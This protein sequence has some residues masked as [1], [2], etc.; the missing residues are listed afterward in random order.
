MN[1]LEMHDVHTHILGFH[2]LEGVSFKI[3]PAKVSVLLGRN[4]AGKSTTMKTIMGLTPPASGEIL[5]KGKPIQKMRDFEIPRLGISLVPEGRDVFSNLTVEE[6]LL[7][8]VRKGKKVKKER[9][10]YI[11]ETFPPMK[12]LFK[13]KGRNLSG[14]EKQMVAVARALVNED[15]LL[16]I[17]EPTKGLAPIIIEGMRLAMAEIKKNATLLLVEQNFEFSTSIADD[18]LIMEHGKI[19]HSGKIEEIKNNAQIQSKYLGV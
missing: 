9:L 3:K 19:V 8:A 10:D 5:F 6:N 2:I 16:L 14:G 4:G 12:D 11:Q 13:K 17:D 7:I 18:F 1:I 15:E